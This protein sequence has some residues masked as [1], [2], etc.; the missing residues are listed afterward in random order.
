MI[1]EFQ[2]G[3]LRDQSSEVLVAVG[4]LRNSCVSHALFCFE[5]NQ[6]CYGDT[7]ALPSQKFGI[8]N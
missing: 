7:L 2:A 3:I 5:K 4:R 8:G 1:S 6:T